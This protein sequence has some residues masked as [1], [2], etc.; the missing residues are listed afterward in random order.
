MLL[1]DFDYELPERLIAQHPVAAREGSRLLHVQPQGLTHL[2]FPQ[3]Q[4]L[5]RPGD[6]LVLNNTKVV[7][8]R[9]RGIKDSGGAA[10]VLLE[11]VLADEYQKLN[12][13][14]CQVRVSKP[15]QRGRSLLFGDQSVECLGREGEFYVL[16]FPTPVFD[17]L[18][19]FGE[20]P[21]PPYIERSDESVEGSQDAL[22]YQTVF[23]AVPGAVAAPTAGLH[24]TTSMLEQ[25]AAM[26][27]ESTYLT[28][29]VGAGTFQPVRVADVSEHQMHLEQYQ[30]P[31]TAVAD[32]ARTQKS[33]G[34]VIAV[35]TTVV[36][37]LESAALA[38]GQ[39]RPGWGESRLF[40]TPGFEFKVVQALITNFHLP[41]STLLMLVSAFAG[42][43]RI[44]AA[45]AE[46]IKKEYRFF[47]FGDAM[48]LHRAD[49]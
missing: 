43:G 20:L 37:A 4:Q 32:I 1:S 14:L 23:A 44:R 35:G 8:A 38:T 30:I 9:L 33:G 24:F 39:L 41:R 13:A 31:D 7:K 3:M 42:S 45:Y 12:R 11:R 19:T 46:A 15:L 6:L 40:I 16:Q 48:F 5:L 29:H 34:R 18:D 47:S 21:L 10:E 49:L 22:R 25:L 36:R 17:F 28:L 27:I 26:G 2:M